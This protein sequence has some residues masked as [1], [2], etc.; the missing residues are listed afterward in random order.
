[1]QTYAKTLSKN[2]IQST[3]VYD[4]EEKKFIGSIDML[5]LLNVTVFLTEAK[6]IVD[7]VATKPVDWN[8]Y[9]AEENKVLADST[10]QDIISK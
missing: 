3:P 10:A 4:A 2:K 1:M 9:I 8:Q 6:Q 5:D 7:V